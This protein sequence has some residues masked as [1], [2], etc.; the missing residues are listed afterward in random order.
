MYQPHYVAPKAELVEMEMQG[1]VLTASGEDPSSL[2]NVEEMII[3]DTPL[4]W[5]NP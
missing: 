4:N 1:F 2:G 5:E 3:D